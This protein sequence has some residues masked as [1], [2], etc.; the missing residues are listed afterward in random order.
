[1]QSEKDDYLSIFKG[2]CF[3]DWLLVNLFLLLAR[4]FLF[5]YTRD[6]GVSG[7]Y[8]YWLFQ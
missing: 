2:F 4:V 7:K 3:L 1:M 8:P 5:V 6:Q